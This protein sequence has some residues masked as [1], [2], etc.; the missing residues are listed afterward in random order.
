MRVC[1]DAHGVAECNGFHVYGEAVRYSALPLAIHTSSSV[2]CG[3]LVAVW[4]PLEIVDLAC[5]MLGAGWVPAAYFV[6][7]RSS[8]REMYAGG[9][10]LQ[11][12][13]VLRGLLL[14][15]LVLAGM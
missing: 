10:V 15:L 11:V 5:C 1:V 8:C 13:C 9:G 3:C 4:I 6:A 2:Q 7:R 12:A 14:D